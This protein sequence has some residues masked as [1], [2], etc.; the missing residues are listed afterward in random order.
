[1]AIYLYPGF[2]IDDRETVTKYHFQSFFFF[3]FNSLNV[4]LIWSFVTRLSVE[5]D[6][7]QVSMHC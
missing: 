7:R 1:M 6:L 5:V 4:L 3:F 2:M